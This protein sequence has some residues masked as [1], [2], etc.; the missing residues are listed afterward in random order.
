[1]G[2]DVTVKARREKLVGDARADKV[3]VVTDTD[4]HEDRLRSYGRVAETATVIE[5]KPI[6][7]VKEG[8]EWTIRFV[9]VG[10]ID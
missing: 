5:A 9:A 10:T 2:P 6:M 7:A 3:M 8:E 1:V 4:E